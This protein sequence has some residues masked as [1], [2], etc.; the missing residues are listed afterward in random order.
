MDNRQ[1]L[2]P[3]KIN[4]NWN[5]FRLTNLKTVDERCLK[6]LK[7]LSKRHNFLKRHLQIPCFVIIWPEL[8]NA[9]QR[10]SKSQ[11]CLNKGK[12]HKSWKDLFK[13]RNFFQN[14][15]LRKT[16]C[17]MVFHQFA[18]SVIQIYIYKVVIVWFE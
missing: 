17:W 12:R 16:E 10:G 8:Q 2:E 11:F 15:L 1:F 14:H 18:L 13:I 4:P 9:T 5:N 3:I 7:H 6:S